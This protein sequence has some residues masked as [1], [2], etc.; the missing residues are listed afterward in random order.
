V[1]EATSV[2]IRVSVDVGSRQH[3]VAIGLS[4]GAVLEEF[5]M[6][7][8]PEGFSA[9]VCLYREGTDHRSGRTGHTRHS[10]L[11]QPI[12][13]ARAGHHLQ[14]HQALRRW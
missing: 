1:S 12:A 9:V 8:Q 6:A 10:S 2:E 7:Y 11:P 3:H 4:N 14:R 5:E 13:D